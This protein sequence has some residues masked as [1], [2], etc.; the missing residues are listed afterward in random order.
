MKRWLVLLVVL[1]ACGG[2][3]SSSPYRSPADIAAKLQAKG[4]CVDFAPKELTSSGAS[5]FEAFEA[6]AGKCTFNNEAVTITFYKDA[7]AK[8]NAQGMAAGFG[9]QLAKGFG[10]KGFDY[11][12]DGLWTVAPKTASTA[13]AIREVIGGSA[14]HIDC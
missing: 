11:V 1:A 10:L 2:G 12:D 9:C 4:G 13:S 8:V 5:G 14:N 7:G 6:S 3:A